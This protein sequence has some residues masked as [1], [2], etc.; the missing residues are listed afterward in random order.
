MSWLTIKIAT[1]DACSVRRICPKTCLNSASSPFV[2]SSRSR[3]SGFRSRIFA[4]A[5][6]CC[7]PPERSY[8]WRSSSSVNLQRETTCASRSVLRSD[9]GKI[10]NKSA[11]TVDFTNNAC[12]FWGSI[13]TLPVM[14]SSP[15]YGLCSLASS[16]SVVV[17]PVP[18]PPSSVRNSPLC[19][20]KDRP[21]T[22]SGR[23]LS[24]LNQSSRAETTVSVSGAFLF[25]SG[26]GCNSCV[27]A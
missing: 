13:P 18:L 24:Y 15:R 21:F 23:S 6:R 1:P 3:T 16:L 22:T 12:G 10:S 14:V 26:I 27:F 19:S 7:S 5:A 17:L 2:G 4:S 8:G 20:S 11:R 9:F 25:S